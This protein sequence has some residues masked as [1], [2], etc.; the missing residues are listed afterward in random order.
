[1][2]NVRLILLLAGGAA[3]APAPCLF[4]AA[5]EARFVPM[6]DAAALDHRFA[7]FEALN[8][9]SLPTGDRLARHDPRTLPWRVADGPIARRTWRNQRRVVVRG[10]YIKAR[11]PK[12]T[13]KY[14]GTLFLFQ[15]CEEVIVERSGVVHLNPDY[16]GQHSFLFENCGRVVLRDVY[17]AGAV[18]RSHIR[19]EGCGEYH[20]ER[21]EI[22]GWDYGEPGVRCGAGIFVNNGITKPD[23]AVHLYAAKRRELQ[24][25]VIRDCWLHDYLTQDEGPWRNQDAI[26]FHAPSNGVVFNCVFDRWLAGDAAIDDSHRRYDPAYKNKAHRIE[27]CV[28]RHCRLVKTDGARGRPDCVIVWANNIYLNTWLADY[29]KGWT[30]WRIHETFVFDEPPPALIK[31]W[32]MQS[33][34]VFANCLL[35]APKGVDVM[36]WQSGK[37]GP[38]G[39]RLFRV[40]HMLYLAPP[41]RYWVCGQGAAIVDRSAWLAQGLE[42]GG[43]LMQKAPGF[44]DAA[45]GDFRL[46]PTS[47]AAGFG[48][49]RYLRPADP[50]LRVARDFYG[51]SRPARPAVG[52]CE[53]VRLN[54]R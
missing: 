10:L 14:K 29:H 34:T 8:L 54:S 4:A 7:A 45:N 28:F 20:I 48:T 32:G 38:D 33:V 37:A 40:D 27:R 2:N 5:R 46:R 21:V 25:G 17:C 42:R 11:W 18:Q 51:R 19:L 31:N 43:A 47:P 6:R 39:Y 23:G 50:A 24:W 15:N 41:P 1:M 53:P 13:T 9:S 44:V 3:C 30:N 35:S 49:P 52:A 16:R 12:A 22:S 26:G 36:F